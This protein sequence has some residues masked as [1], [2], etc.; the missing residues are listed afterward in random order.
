MGAL[1]IYIDDDDDDDDD[2]NCL[3]SASQLAYRVFVKRQKDSD[4]IC[5]NWNFE[6]R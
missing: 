3:C 5:V 6:L 4:N 1:Q 2:D